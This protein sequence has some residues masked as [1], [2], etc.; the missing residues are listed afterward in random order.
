MNRRDIRYQAAVMR[1]HHALLLF[2]HDRESGERFWAFPGGGREAGET[3]EECVR[4]EISEETGLDVDVRG[5][6]FTTPDIPGGM[7]D[8]L[9]T[10]HCEIV[11]GT[12]T[13]GIEPEVD[14][15]DHMTIRDLAWFDLRDSRGWGAAITQDP[16]TYPLLQQLCTALGYF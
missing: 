9:H 12:A 13:P 2:V 6:L 11:G 5:L 15:A 7:Y 16:I 1:D 3:A 4:R 14:D 8:M 10:Y